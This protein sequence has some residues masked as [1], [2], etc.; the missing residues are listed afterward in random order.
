MTS[1]IYA[2]GAHPTTVL[3]V[4]DV[5]TALDEVALRYLAMK[6]ARAANGRVPKLS[7]ERTE[8]VTEPHFFGLRSRTREVQVTDFSYWELGRV[9]SDGYHY[10]KAPT[11][12]VFDDWGHTGEGTVVILR[13]DG[14]LLGADFYVRRGQRLLSRQ[15]MLSWDSDRLSNIRQ[16]D[17]TVLTIL[18]HERRELYRD[19]KRLPNGYSQY[20]D[21]EYHVLGHQY[22]KHGGGVEQALNNLMRDAGNDPR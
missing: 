5:P 20:E 10:C 8:M 17:A 13:D 19:R 15:P 18:D 12:S 14:E 2:L 6:V 3:G 21:F 1:P 4:C 9:Q 7:Q 22:R 11:A 16:A